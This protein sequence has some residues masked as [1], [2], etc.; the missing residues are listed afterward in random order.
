MTATKE[1][2]LVIDG[3]GTR[4]S[5]VLADSHGQVVARALGPSTNVAQRSL[6]VV[7]RALES[8][9][10]DC[11]AQLPEHEPSLAV[12]QQHARRPV[13][14]R[15]VWAGLAG[16]DS[17]QAAQEARS[18]LLPL[19][20][21][22]PR[23]LAEED[24][25]RLRVTNDSELLA[26]AIGGERAEAEGETRRGAVLIAGTGSVCTAFNG[27]QA[28]GRT[29][30]LGYLLGDDG[31][32]FWIGREVVRRLLTQ[33]SL[34]TTT[35]SRTRGMLQVAVLEL[36]GLRECSELIARVYIETQDDQA[37]KALL[38][39]LAPCV[40]Q[41]A[42]V[43]ALASA[44]LDEALAHLFE[45]VR[46]LCVAHDIDP[47]EGVLVLGGGLFNELVVV[48]RFLARCEHNRMVWRKISSGKRPEEIAL[49]FMLAEATAGST[50]A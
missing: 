19:F 6:A 15:R 12:A 24:E 4:T 17:A 2:Y 8:L 32:G 5:A 27:V 49:D 28:L 38:A 9:V 10:G 42:D 41:L 36:L 40:H 50:A 31:S 29:G 45:L 48:R 21:F 20:G 16:I 18:A 7:V 3:G 23:G 43:D 30:G 35:T 47:R 11:L 34:R 22:T 39:S 37:R 44:I 13:V 25:T 14:F 1:L 33:D 46:S 26:G